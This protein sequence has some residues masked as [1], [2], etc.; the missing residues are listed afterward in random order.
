L[1]VL[2]AFK[3]RN[4]ELMAARLANQ[5][6]WAACIAA[7]LWAFFVFAIG[8]AQSHPDWTTSTPVAVGG[9][10]VIWICGRAARYVLSR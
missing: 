1:V 8:A 10:F 7:V 2:A 6:Y 5:I 4:I 9:A 3:R